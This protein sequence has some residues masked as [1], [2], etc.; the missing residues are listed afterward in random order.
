MSS[1][2][3]P[4][5]L[6]DWDKFQ[7]LQRAASFVRRYG[8]V[9]ALAPFVIALFISLRFDFRGTDVLIAVSLAWAGVV[10]VCGLVVSGRA[11]FISC[12]SCGS[13]F[14]PGNACQWCDFPRHRPSQ[15]AGVQA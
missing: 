11:L 4:A 7:R 3:S 1:P 13:H 6:D 5:C 9:T 8:H 10:A 14:G 15:D 2:G 12:P